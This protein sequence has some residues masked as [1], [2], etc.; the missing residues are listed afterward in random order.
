MLA[1][2]RQLLLYVCATRDYADA[3]LCYA[4]DIFFAMLRHAS[5]Q[6][7]MLLPLRHERTQMLAFDAG[8]SNIRYA[9]K[10]LPPRR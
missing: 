5:R 2:R 8:A 1:R 7:L 3:P 6:R 10:I 9:A 4:S